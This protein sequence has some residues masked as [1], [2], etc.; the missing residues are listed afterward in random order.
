MSLDDPRY[1]SHQLGIGQSLGQYAGSVG[2]LHNWR[3]Q[4][5]ARQQAQYLQRLSLQQPMLADGSSLPPGWIAIDPSPTPGNK[6][7]L[8]LE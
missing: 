8:L 1:H 3:Q 6:L 7:L 2:G 4:E 5:A